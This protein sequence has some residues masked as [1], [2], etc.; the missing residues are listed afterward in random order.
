MGTEDP[1]LEPLNA[2]ML[3]LRQEAFKYLGQGSRVAEMVLAM[4]D[5][6]ATHLPA[7]SDEPDDAHPLYQHG[8]KA[9]YKHGAWQARHCAAQ[10]A[11]S[12][13]PA[14][15]DPLHLSRIL[16]E[17]AGAVSL[18]WEPWPSGV[19]E[20]SMACGYVAAAIAEI[21]SRMTATAQPA[22]AL[23]PLTDEQVV[24]DAIMMMPTSIAND[25]AKACEYGIR[26]AE[27]AHGI[28]APGAPDAAPNPSGKGRPLVDVPLTNVLGLAATHPGR[29]APHEAGAKGPGA[30]K[31]SRPE[32]CGE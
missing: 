8:W 25:C 1:G 31:P 23:V 26:Y 7:A 5:A 10:P 11:A 30:L 28:T 24:M 15:P 18:C 29:S 4:L 12:E 2:L 16:H 3:D 13:E 32:A 9:G 21:R 14:N 22:P 19:F 27:R 20:S 17:M 6:S